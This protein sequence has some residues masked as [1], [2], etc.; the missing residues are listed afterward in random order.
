MPTAVYLIGLLLSSIFSWVALFIILT[1][2]DPV[3]DGTLAISL[4]FITLFFALTSTF[5]LIGFYARIWWRRNEIYYQNINIAFR[6]GIL[7]SIG[8]CGLMGLQA[9]RVLTWW[10]A[11]LLGVTIVLIEVLSLAKMEQRNG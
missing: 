9:L 11:L 3:L 2:L 5:A 8:V 7:L 1:K 10:D 4:F 6:Q